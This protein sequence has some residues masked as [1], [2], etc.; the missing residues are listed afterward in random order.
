MSNE[1]LNISPPHEKGANSAGS[2]GVV[3]LVYT[4]KVLRTKA[5]TYSPVGVAKIVSL[6]LAF[7]AC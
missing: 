5:V 7:E 1:Y 2:R 6:D 3:A 4:T